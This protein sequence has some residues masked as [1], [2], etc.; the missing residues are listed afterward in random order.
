VNKERAIALLQNAIGILEA[1]IGSA[2]LVVAAPQKSEVAPV[3]AS[4]EPSHV[5][6]KAEVR[7][8]APRALSGFVGALQRQLGDGGADVVG[9]PRNRQAH[10]D[11]S[12]AHPRH[13]TRRHVSR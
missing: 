2:E 10:G 12:E 4:D 8:P 6:P 9:N 11:P 7:T 1:E 5:P 3:I 13:C